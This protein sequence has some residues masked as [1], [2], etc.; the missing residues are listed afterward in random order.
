MHKLALQN[1]ERLLC[2]SRAHL[3]DLPLLRIEIHVEVRRLHPLPLELRVL[4][5]VL[6]EIVLRIRC[7]RSDTDQPGDHER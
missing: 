4:N 7:K 2:H 1:R 3:R 6:P 5:F